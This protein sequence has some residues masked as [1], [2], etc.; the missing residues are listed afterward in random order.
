MWW[1][2]RWYTWYWRYYSLKR[3]WCFCTWWFS[4]RR[5]WCFCTWCFCW[6]RS[7]CNST[8]WFYYIWCR[9]YDRWCKSTFNERLLFRYIWL[10]IKVINSTGSVVFSLSVY[11]LLLFLPESS[12]QPPLVHIL[13]F[14]SL[15]YWFFNF[16]ERPHFV[17]FH[18][19]S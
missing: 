14:V 11:L 15:F 1:C 3:K 6:R 13:Y 10:M 5:K 12:L 7:W 4:W 17:R 2:C 9:Y 18:L 8:W 19:V 16:W